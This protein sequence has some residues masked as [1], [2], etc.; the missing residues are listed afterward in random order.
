MTA[1]SAV[2]ESPS[3]T[4]IRAQHPAL[5][6]GAT[7]VE[8]FAAL[9][10]AGLRHLERNVA[11]FETQPEPNAVHQMR[12]AVRRL[13]ALLGAFRPV[14]P[15][16]QRKRVAADLKRFQ[17]CLGPARDLDVFLDD[18]LPSLRF[19]PARTILAGAA[20]APH[21]RAYTRVHRVAR[22][23]IPDRLRSGFARLSDALAA[24][25]EGRRSGRSLGRKILERRYRAL[26]RRLDGAKARSDERL[27]A[28]RIR[29]KKLRYAVEFF[30]PLMPKG[31]VKSF[32]AA[33]AESQDIL[34]AFNDA[35]N[36]RALARTLAL[37]AV[38]LNAE[39]RRMLDS[40]FA[41]AEARARP[42]VQRKLAGQQKALA[43]PPARWFR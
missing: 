21:R 8:T 22:G 36:A 28:L 6:T 23:P 19:V 2:A 4:P 26:V 29:I 27:H 7:V 25:P 12:V 24:A 13:R 34:G 16:A 33:L 14:L 20:R 42:R 32:H 37:N 40:T 39:T 15:K 43:A 35:V 3:V 11:A 38:G 10:G 9:T 1:E 18:V 41:A 5:S 17:K 30:R 31:G